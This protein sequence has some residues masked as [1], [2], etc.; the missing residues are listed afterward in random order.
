MRRDGLEERKDWPKKMK[1]SDSKNEK[2][3]T[4]KVGRIDLKNE[5]GWLKKWEGL[6]LNME[7]LSQNTKVRSQN[8]EGLCGIKE[9]ILT[10]HN[11]HIKNLQLERYYQDAWMSY[12]KRE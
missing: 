2:D 10:P 11:H 4:E 5:K 9:V 6:T 12:T 3:W 1:K 7:G 8:I